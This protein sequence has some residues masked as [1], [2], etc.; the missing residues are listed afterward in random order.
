[1]GGRTG[2]GMF[3]LET[4]R[5]LLDRHELSDARAMNAWEN[6]PEILRLSDSRPPGEAP[7]PLSETRETI[8]RWLL[9]ASPEFLRFAIRPRGGGP[10]LGFGSVAFVDP[11]NRSCKLSVV[12]GDPAMRGKGFAREALAAVIGHSFATLRMNR[13]GAEIFAFN[14]ASIRL[15]ESLGFRREGACREAVR[16]SGGFADE[17]LY[18]LLRREWTGGGAPRPS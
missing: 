7:V 16:T 13:I 3:R 5:L 6:D 2:R 8:E 9:E 12:I 15:F 4:E 17:L 11:W 18:G 14:A 1:M 10:P